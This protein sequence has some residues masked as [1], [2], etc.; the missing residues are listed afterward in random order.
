MTVP[1][2]LSIAGS[3]PSGGAGIQADLKTFAAFGVYG[4]AALT[5]LTA[6][7][8]RGVS[9]V[10]ELEPAFV[11]QQIEAVLS[12]LRVGAVKLG[13]L[14][15]AAIV[16]AVAA[17]LEPWPGLPV[18]LDPVMLAKGGAALLMP[19]AV[20]VLRERLLPRAALITPNLPEAAA[21]LS[22][23]G[24]VGQQSVSEARVAAEPEWACEQLLGLGAQAVLLKGGHGSGA[25]STDILAVPREGAGGRPVL[26]RLSLPRLSTRNTHGT[27]CTLSAAI[28]AGLAHGRSLEQAVRDAKDF[29][30]GA[31]AAAD[32]L[33][34]TRDASEAGDGHGPLHHLFS[35][36]RFFP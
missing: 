31:L 23:T 19:D 9:A 27:G 22:G 28:A 34:V 18:V 15:R 7:N 24:Q 14:S 33:T 30:Q 13:M 12:D 2:A 17:A 21:L 3:D 11:R 10:A 4:A 8:T 5:S 1:V 6:Q 32:S 25:Q 26:T 29:V 36:G 35:W 16:E 20:A